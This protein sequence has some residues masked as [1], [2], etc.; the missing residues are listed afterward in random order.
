MGRLTLRLPD[1]LHQQVANL[2]KEEGVSLNHFIVYALTRQ[3]TLTQIAQIPP[4][5]RQQQQVSYAALLESLGPPASVQEMHTVLKERQMVYPE[6]TLTLESIQK[7]TAI[8]LPFWEQ[9]LG[10]GTMLDNKKVSGEKNASVQLTVGQL[11][12]SGLIGL[13]ADRKDIADSATY[14][15][16][17]REQ[18]QR[19]GEIRYDPAG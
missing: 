12:E 17:L 16:E 10:E 6:P 1:T 2:A 5:E 14:A 13:W 3:V 4:E 9:L 8:L 7:L 18:A 15:R 19:R 11:R